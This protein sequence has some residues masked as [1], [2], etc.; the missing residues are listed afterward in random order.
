MS[1]L[2]R[3]Q[4][5]WIDFLGDF[6]DVDKINQDKM[7]FWKQSLNSAS[8]FFFLV[9]SFS[10]KFHSFCDNCLLE[11]VR[12]DW[13]L[14]TK[15]SYS[16]TTSHKISWDSHICHLSLTNLPSPL[17][18]ILI[19][20]EYVYKV[21]LYKCTDFEDCCQVLELVKGSLFSNQHIHTTA[22]NTIFFHHPGLCV[23]TKEAYF[24][25]ISTR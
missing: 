2:V 9:F 15:E 22:I 12:I 18:S 3:I 8:F 23:Y 4:I 1:D 16:T 10:H 7:I 24:L 13:I 17:V 21:S 14:V 20:P 19:V 25:C 5:M 11:I 6:L